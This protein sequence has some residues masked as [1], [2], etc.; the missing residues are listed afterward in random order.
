MYRWDQAL[1]G[2]ELLSQPLLDKLF[3]PMAQIPDPMGVAGAYGYGWFIGERFNQP[4]IWHGGG[5][6]GFR[7]QIDRYPDRHAT[8]I[9]LSNREDV[10][11]QDITSL[12]AR[13]ILEDE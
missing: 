13:M 2:T 1:Y 6:E 12:M 4:R 5:I 9:V 3:M 10:N 7:S 11:A 8:I